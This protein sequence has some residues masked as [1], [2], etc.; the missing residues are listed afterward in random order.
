MPQINIRLACINGVVLFVVIGVFVF[1]A[2]LSR[3]W[4]DR[5]VIESLLASNADL[6]LFGLETES[7]RYV[8]TL[9]PANNDA[10]VRFRAFTKLPAN[11]RE[12]LLR[13]RHL[14][15]LRLTGELID[16]IDLKC[17]TKMP[18]LEEL[19]LI[20]CTIAC[21]AQINCV[22][23]LSQ[24]NINGSECDASGLRILTRG[25][26]LLS[27]HAAES[28]LDRRALRECLDRNRQLR[29]LDLTGTNGVCDA[30]DA[31]AHL[32]LLSNLNL[33]NSDISDQCGTFVGRLRKLRTLNISGTQISDDFLMNLTQMTDLETIYM[34]D[35]NRVSG[36]A[37]TDVRRAL[38]DV[39]VRS[40]HQQPR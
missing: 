14:M 2:Y 1:A 8:S 29:V 9:P 15:H 31:F 39:T 5:D 11:V 19:E 23:G 21:D 24:L 6:G 18:D 38:P 35:C 7:G 36:K 33:G 34:F 26:S 37:I 28:M 4:P 32:G 22:L 12:H 13:T 20:N 40:M 27:L 16:E 30:A 3:Q 17:L 10:L 25:G